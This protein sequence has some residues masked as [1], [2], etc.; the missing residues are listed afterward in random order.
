LLV[1]ELRSQQNVQVA[2]LVKELD[3]K[4]KI[5][6][7]PGQAEKDFAEWSQQLG[8]VK[9]Q[10]V[11]LLTD[12]DNFKRLNT[13]YSEPRVDQSLLPEA[14]QLIESLIR[15]R[16]GA[17]KYGGDEYV[18]ILPNCDGMEGAGFA[19]K[20]RKSFE[21]H[22][23]KVDTDAVHVTISIGV[24]VWPVHA[25]TYQDLLTKAS[26]AKTQAKIQKNCFR[27]A[28]LISDQDTPLPRS[29]LSLPAQNL[30][31]YLSIKSQNGLS[32]DPM[33]NPE[34]LCNELGCTE[35]TLALAAD[36][37]EEHGWVKLIRTSG[38]G[39]AG[40]S[41]LAP[42][43]LLFIET[44]PFNRGSDPKSDAR[45]LATHLIKQ[46]EGSASLSELD[47]Q[48]SWGPRRINPAVSFL[49]LK[50]YVQSSRTHNA[51]PY[52]ASWI[53]VTEKTKRFALSG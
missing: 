25:M 50:E 12:L 37:L 31:V 39:K 40:F 33:V 4:F 36:E 15:L 47:K 52:T 23:F 26:E 34:T 3:Q 9:G 16:G 29:G 49:Q 32:H 10:I 44:D 8:S 7:S 2:T 38:M 6:L 48:L 45:E 18:L 19:E 11:V 13:K 27:M 17:Y 41:S 24:A 28:A 43:P 46:P 20:V 5:L 35:D 22:E 14:M 30:A 1:D 51:Y 53:R 42:A 21:Q